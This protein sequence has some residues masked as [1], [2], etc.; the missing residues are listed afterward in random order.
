MKDADKIILTKFIGECWHEY[1][2]LNEYGG[3]TSNIRCKKCDDFKWGVDKGL[4]RKNPHMFNRDFNTWADFGVLWEATKG[5]GFEDI[6]RAEWINYGWYKLID[7]D[8]LP[9]L[10]LEELKNTY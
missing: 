6:W 8:R 1:I 10:V 7:K 2:I 5:E 3:S 4:L 9:L